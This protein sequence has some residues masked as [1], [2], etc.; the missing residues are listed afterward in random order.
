M[1]SPMLPIITAVMILSSLPA[2]AEDGQNY[3]TET[4]I[5]YEIS[6]EEQYPGSREERIDSDSGYPNVFSLKSNLLFWCADIP[7]L[8]ASVSF[9]KHWSLNF[10]VLYCPWMIDDNYSLKCAMILPEIRIWPKTNLKGHFLDFHL[11]VGWYNLRWKDYRYQDVD[12]P[13]IGAGIGYGYHLE[14]NKNWGLEFSIGAG[15][16]NTRYNRFYNVKNGAVA[17]TKESSYWG[18]DRVGISIVYRICDL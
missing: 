8:G 6:Q 18:I 16:F 2:W 12:R 7:N 15:Y 11:S 4:E 10:D 9:G 5:S 14:L 17:D 3:F 13:L 1:Y